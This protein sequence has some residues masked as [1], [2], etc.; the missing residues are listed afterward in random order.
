[1]IKTKIK[2][3]LSIKCVEYLRRLFA[4]GGIQFELCRYLAQHLAPSQQSA[5]CDVAV[6]VLIVARAIS[7]IKKYF[8]KVPPLE[9]SFISLTV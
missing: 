3:F 7:I 5:R 1:V 4:G 6:A 8:I 9:F 2:N